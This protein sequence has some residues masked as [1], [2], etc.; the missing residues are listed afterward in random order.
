M[1]SRKS[2]WRLYLSRPLNDKEEPVRPGE[3]NI[4]GKIKGFYFIFDDYPSTWKV[5]GVLVNLGKETQ[6]V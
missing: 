3:K 2:F 4:P 5:A 6:E 1:K